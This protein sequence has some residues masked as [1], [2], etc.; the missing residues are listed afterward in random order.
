MNE[1]RVTARLADHATGWLGTALW[2]KRDMN[3]EKEKANN[4]E[5]Q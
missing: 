5:V 2:Q 4:P 3:K 1:N